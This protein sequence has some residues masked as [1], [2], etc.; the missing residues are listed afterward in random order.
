[1]L[2]IVAATNFSEKNTIK[3]KRYKNNE[4]HKKFIKQ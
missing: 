3:N 1:M 4:I 2:E